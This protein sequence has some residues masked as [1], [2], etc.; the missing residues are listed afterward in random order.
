MISLTPM[1]KMGTQ[2]QKLKP[3]EKLAFGVAENTDYLRYNSMLTVAD[4]N[5]DG[6]GTETSTSKV[7]L[8]AALKEKSPNCKTNVHPYGV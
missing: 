1:M 7:I 4:V 3:K 5:F 6:V 8:V 2:Y